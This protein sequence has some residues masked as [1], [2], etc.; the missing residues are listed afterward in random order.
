MR[1]EAHPRPDVRVPAEGMQTWSAAER[2]KAELLLEFVESR[3]EVHPREVEEHFAHG[4]VRNY[5]GGPSN[6]TT[7]SGP[8]AHE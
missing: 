6:A 4:R 3:C 8:A 7:P 2:R 5:W 1:G